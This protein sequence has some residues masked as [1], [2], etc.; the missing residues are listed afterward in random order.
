MLEQA[1]S[2]SKDDKPVAGSVATLPETPETQEPQG[3]F[4]ILRD[5]GLLM[6][7]TTP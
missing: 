4:E 7:R 5:L 2:A 3:L 1:E 6:G